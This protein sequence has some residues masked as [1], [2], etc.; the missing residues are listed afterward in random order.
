MSSKTLRGRGS[1]LVESCPS[2]PLDPF[3]NVNRP[4]SWA[5]K[6]FK[7]FSQFNILSNMIIESWFHQTVHCICTFHALAHLTSHL[8]TQ[9]IKLCTVGAFQM[10]GFIYQHS[11]ILHR[12][13][14]SKS[15][16]FILSPRACIQIQQVTPSE[17]LYLGQ[18]GRVFL[19]TADVHHLLRAQE[20]NMAWN[21]PICLN[22]ERTHK[23]FI[24]LTY[25]LNEQLKQ[26]WNVLYGTTLLKPKR[27]QPR[28]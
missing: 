21:S 27:Q 8:I 2:C 17:H 19:P 24:P 11:K 25:D 16:C 20:F 18:S 9:L 23:P 13:S 28:V 14:V 3:P 1:L 6:M 26:K 22:D 12:P 7:C 4:P 5:N 10:Y 15:V